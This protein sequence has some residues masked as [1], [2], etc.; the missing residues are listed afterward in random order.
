MKALVTAEFTDEGVCR[1]EALGYQ[2]ERAG[3]GVTGE[4]LDRPALISAAAGAQLVLTEIEQIDEH[5]LAAL[6]E[7]GL[8]GT[9]RG[10]PVNI[11]IAACAA[12]GISVLFTPGRNADSVADFTMGLVLGLV[13][14]IPAAERHLR[15]VGWLVGSALP[16]L[17]FRGPELAGLR[18][19]LVGYGAVGER[20]A[21][22]A[23]DGFGM[24]VLFSDPYVAG[25]TGFDELLTVSDI[26][27]LHCPRL[28]ETRHLIGAGALARMRRGSYL[29]NTAGGD[30]VDAAA[31]VVALKS[32]HLAGAA[33]DVF[34]TE[35][36]P[37][38]SPL[39]QTPGLV[40]TP[41]LAGAAYDVVRHHTDLLCSDVERWHRGEDLVHAAGPRPTRTHKS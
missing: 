26:V 1:L 31:L 37:R 38:D 40:L 29:I 14:Q 39:L 17:H 34:A 22:R 3:W 16:Y 15:E 2:V 19:G 41:H 35:P 25:A 28:P 20:V 27:S 33:L 30:I 18:L 6:P 8:I 9:A 24:K 5:V 13:R 36:V 21:Q 4:V 23:R 12:R 11:D 7:L 10:G 32:G